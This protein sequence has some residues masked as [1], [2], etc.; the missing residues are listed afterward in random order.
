MGNGMTKYVAFL[1]GINVGGHKLIKMADLAQIFSSLGLKNVKTYIVSGNVLF[2]T[3]EQDPAVL[4]K[5]IEKGLEKALGYEVAVILR[6]VAELEY[7]INLDPFKHLKAGA[8]VKKYVT[9][10]SEKH[11]S[12]LKV[13]ALSPKKDWEIIH[14]NPR[15]VFIVAHPVVGRYGESMMLVEKEFGKSV[16][17][18]NW[19][20]VVKIL[21]LAN[22]G[23]K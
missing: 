10:L 16:T 21:S 6:T 11:T 15:E 13:P 14:L 4:T 8:D 12:K 23:D 17:T 5:K 2:E 19:N 3:P 22:P 18:R 1:R 7:L 9:F 20:T